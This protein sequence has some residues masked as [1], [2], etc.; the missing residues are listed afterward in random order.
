FVACVERIN[1]SYCHRLRAEAYAARS[2]ASTA[3]EWAREL[4][5]VP[6][7]SAALGTLGAAESALG[8]HAC[9]LEHLRRA[10]ELRRPAGP[11]PRLGDN[12][13]ALAAAALAAGAVDE[14]RRAADELLA[15]YRDNPR[16]APQPTEWLWTAA[17]VARAQGRSSAA[18]QLVRQA[19]SVMRARASVIDDDDARV[20]Y[21][22]L[23]FNRALRATAAAVTAG[24]RTPG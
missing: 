19:Q 23:P 21:L 12:L 7:E 6:L 22:D 4:G 13:C 18:A 14:A 10:V 15:L 1:A 16:L 20:A 9:A 17:Q 24:P 8:E 3:L 2:A 5:A 11:T